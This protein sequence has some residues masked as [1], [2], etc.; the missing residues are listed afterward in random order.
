MQQKPKI[1]EMD[2]AELETI[3]QHCQQKG[4]DPEECEKLA[5]LM[6]AYENLLEL[7][8]AGKISLRRL[9]KMLFGASTEKTDDVL[10]N[11]GDRPSSESASS[12]DASSSPDTDTD[13]SSTKSRQGHGRNGADDYPGARTVEISHS[14]LQAGDAC[15]DCGQ[16]TVYDTGRP[17][18]LIRFVARPPLEA[19]VY[20]TQK[21]RC[22]LCGKLFTADL[23]EEAGTQKYDPT[24]GSMIG[25][26][27][28]GSGLPFNRLE[29]LQ[30]NLGMPLPA[31]TQWFIVRDTAHTLYPAYLELIRQAAQGDVVYN[32]DTAVKILELMGKGAKQEAFA[33]DMQ[34]PGAKDS[35][36]SSPK[37]TGL[38]TSGIVSTSAGRR[39]ALF[40]SGRK[41]AGE[42][43]CQV[44]AERA[45]ELE[46]PI[47]MC[48]ALSRNMPRELKTILANCLAH[49]RRNFVD[50]AELFRDECRYVLETLKVVYKNEADARQENLGPEARLEF[51][52][53]HS[54]PLMDDLKA[55][56]DRQFD[57]RL[58]EPNS[59]LGGAISYMQN[60]WE[61]LTLFLRKAGAPLDN[62]V[63]ERALKKA[64][65]HRKNSLFYKTRNGALVGDL[66][67]SLI[68][69]CE[70]CGTNPF[71]YLTDLQRHAEQLSANPQ[72]WMPWN[73]HLALA[74]EAASY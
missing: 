74:Q 10:G 7:V 69:T 14:S 16:G 8:K 71:D 2:P 43:L 17:G 70:L 65:L 27:K 57:D 6:E 19:T 46:A 55:W 26:L 28:Y 39:I 1:I 35:A 3:L 34:P 4:V 40:F 11:S 23:P 49:A 54:G 33:E 51:H 53:V 37:R 21:L 50:L 66:L 67:M 24:V 36:N 48:D 15:P 9:Q 56:L 38:F 41:H 5:T 73:Y 58:V 42:N 13:E 68:Y 45:T 30:G 72:E 64:I 32:D 12:P 52:K 31:S 61:K 59:S 47:Q 18:V 29:G 22:H 63:C 60:H 44:L 62:N 25:L 20:R